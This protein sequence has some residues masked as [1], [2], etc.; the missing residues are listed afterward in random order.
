MFFLRK[1]RYREFKLFF[2]IIKW[3]GFDFRKVGFRICFYLLCD[4]VSVF[5]IRGLERVGEDLLIK[6]GERVW[7]IGRLRY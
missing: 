3:L 6:F 4:V 5:G 2:L 1:S 7:V